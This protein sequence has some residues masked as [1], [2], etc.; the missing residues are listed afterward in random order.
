[1][2]DGDN[3][4][5]WDIL[6]EAYIAGKTPAALRESE[7]RLNQQII[8][9]LWPVGSEWPLPIPPR[10]HAEAVAT[11]EVKVVVLASL[12]TL[13]IDPIEWTDL[14]LAALAADLPVLMSVGY[15]PLWQLMAIYGGVDPIVEVLAHSGYLAVQAAI[16]LVPAAVHARIMT[17][18]PEFM[19]QAVATP[20]CDPA[21]LMDCFSG[22]ET[23]VLAALWQLSG[24]SYQPVFSR[25]H[26][27]IQS[28]V[29]ADSAFRWPV[30]WR[31]YSMI[32]C[33]LWLADYREP[34][35]ESFAEH[36][37]NQPPST[38]MKTHLDRLVWRDRQWLISYFYRRAN[39]GAVQTREQAWP[40][41][42]QLCAWYTDT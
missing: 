28:V 17:Q 32:R 4:V 13:S 37:L 39:Q 38:A 18:L 2:M 15:G 26:L 41:H 9:A 6:N 34:L 1:M 12:Q 25:V 3:P 19:T 10:D 11:L 21:P 8:D 27:A 14:R 40:L 22:D 35:L 7:Q 16:H 36:W 33:V 24:E 29:Q 20:V 5:G 30:W 42:K 23:A 31:A